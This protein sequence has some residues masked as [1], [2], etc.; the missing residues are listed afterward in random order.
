MA[1]KIYLLDSFGEG[2]P[3]IRQYVEKDG[4]SNYKR[5]KKMLDALNLALEEELTARQRE[6]FKM[7]YCEDLTVSQIAR[8][9]KVNKSTVSRIIKRADSR[10]KNIFKYNLI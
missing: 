5:R 10:L 6:V 3:A 2:I 4:E 7:R 8:I 9:L 1:T